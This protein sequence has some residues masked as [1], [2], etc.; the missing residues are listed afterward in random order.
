MRGERRHSPH[1]ISP[2]PDGRMRCEK[3]YTSWWCSGSLGKGSYDAGVLRC[4]IQSAAG[5]GSAARRIPWGGRAFGM[6]AAE[7]NAPVVSALIGRSSTNP[8]TKPRLSQ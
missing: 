5:L 7:V 8:E 6:S 1:I 4:Y 3:S 2:R